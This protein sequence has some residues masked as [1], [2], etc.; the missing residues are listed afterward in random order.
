MNIYD[1]AL[2][3]IKIRPHSS[4]ELKKKLT[5]RGFNVEEVQEVTETLKSQGLIN[6]SAYAENYLA[7]LIRNKTFGF[8]GL[9]AKLLQ[10]GIEKTE[11]ERVLKEQLSQEVEKTIALKLVGRKDWDKLKLAQTLSRKGFRTQVISTII[12]NL[13][14]TSLPDA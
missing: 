12:Q 9:L 10:R 4:G 14:A 5:L 1:K 6:D 3:F 8:Y 13:D 2:Q 11:A 7:E